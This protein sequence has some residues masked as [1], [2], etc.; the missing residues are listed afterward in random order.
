MATN[1]V[2]GCI[3]DIVFLDICVSHSLHTISV[4][5]IKNTCYHS[6]NEADDF[7]PL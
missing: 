7:W 5:M 4:Y 6:W 1:E 2:F 3:G